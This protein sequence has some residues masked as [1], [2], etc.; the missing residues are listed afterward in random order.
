MSIKLF[1][2]DIDGTILDHKNNEIPESTCKTL[3]HLR[4][5][6]HIVGVATGRN[7]SQLEKAIDPN[8]FDF[9]I[10]CNGGYLQING[11]KVSDN[12]FSQEQKNKLCDLLDD[13][14]YEYGITTY[15]HLYAKNPD[16]YGVVK[17]IEDFKV[18]T[19]EQKDDLRDLELYQFT[20]Y[21]KEISNSCISKIE[22]EFQLYALGDFAYDVV[23]PSNNKG[24]MIKDVAEMYQIDMKNTIAFGDGDNDA[25]LLKEAGVGV[26]MGNGTDNAKSSS[27]FVTTE[28]Y[29]NGI[30]NA[31]R[32]LGYIK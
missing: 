30:Y 18:I 3:R 4:D 31:V 15:H 14:G 10:L 19:P 24:N 27:D 22:E 13:Y 29:N 12:Q 6:G 7:L 23:I 21:E 1:V 8:E 25:M 32:K 2:F 17:I 16:Y 9:C 20:I 28:S 26:A 5:E 11:E